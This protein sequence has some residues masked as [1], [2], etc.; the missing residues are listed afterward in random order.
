MLAA[1]VVKR[2]KK[3]LKVI[4]DPR[5]PFPEENITAKRWTGD[6]LTYNIWKKLE[7]YYLMQADVTIAIANT[8]VKHFNKIVPDAKFEVIPN[9]VDTDIFMSDKHAGAYFRHKFGI[10]KDEIIFIYSGSM[11]NN[12]NNADIYAKCLI[13]LRRLSMKHRFIFLTPNTK[14][15]SKKLEQY[16]I[17]TNEYFAI[18]IQFNNM[19]KYLS[20]GDFGINLMEIKD[21]RMSIKT[22]EYLSMGLPIIINSNVLGAKE[23]VEKYNIGFV[24]NIED[25]N[26]NELELFIK[27]KSKNLSRKCREIAV[28]KFAT[29]IIAKKYHKIYL[30]LVT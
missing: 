30:C 6:S 14:E 20:I 19:P 9:N 12:W 11:G 18:S 25:I 23:L 26:L 5:S 15:L 3:E 21:I 24:V 27:H 16:K 10:A 28:K 17:N 13:S 29:D 7:K 2:L 1:I 8:Y 4:F 22:A